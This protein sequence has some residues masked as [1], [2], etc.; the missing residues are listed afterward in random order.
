MI[1]M[2]KSIQPRGKLSHEDLVQHLVDHH[3]HQL[4]NP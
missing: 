2:K 3:L 1:K 4:A